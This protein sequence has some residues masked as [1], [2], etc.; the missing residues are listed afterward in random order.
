[1]KGLRGEDNRGKGGIG[2]GGGWVVRMR[3]VR[4]GKRG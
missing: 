1:M 2:G 4:R 3:D